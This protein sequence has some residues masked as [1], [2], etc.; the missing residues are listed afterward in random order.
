MT[1]AAWNPHL[2]DQTSWS[3]VLCHVI[4]IIPFEWHA[5]VSINILPLVHYPLFH[6]AQMQTQFNSFERST[7]SSKHFN[8][9]YAITF[10]TYSWHF[11]FFSRHFEIFHELH[12]ARSGN[13][14]PPWGV[15]IEP[16]VK[17]GSTS[18]NNTRC[19]WDDQTGW[20]DGVLET[21]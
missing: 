21:A 15:N 2:Q 12:N 14:T 19:C 6:L 18:S 3:I 1:V 8:F 4:L 13:N 10:Q 5:G 9:I 20:R 17:S 11:V 16:P 7:L